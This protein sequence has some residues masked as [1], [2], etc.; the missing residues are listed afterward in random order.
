MMPLRSHHEGGRPAA[1]RPQE[2]VEVHAHDEVGSGGGSARGPRCTAS[3]RRCGSPCAG[4]AAGCHGGPASASPA[5]AQRC[6]TNVPLPSRGSSGVEER[7]ATQRPQRLPSLEARRPLLEEGAGALPV[8][9][10]VEGLEL[11]LAPG[12]GDALRPASTIPLDLS[13][14]AP[15]GQRRVARRPPG[16]RS[17]ASSS[18]AGSRRWMSPMRRPPQRR[19]A[20]PSTGC[21]WRRR[22]PRGP[23]AGARPRGP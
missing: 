9:L 2:S 6:P 1:A 21:P 19:R 16:S 15:H 5:R 11:Q 14:A 22:A 17:V 18:A 12:A 3:G 7:T 10:A 4:R 20:R 8:V 13:L 23:P